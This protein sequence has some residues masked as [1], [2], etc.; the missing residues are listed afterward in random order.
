MS[1]SVTAV[2]GVQ[3]VEVSSR[4][5]H[6]DVA[7]VQ[8]SIY[9]PVGEEGIRCVLRAERM[10]FSSPLVLAVPGWP[11]GPNPNRV[12]GIQQGVPTVIDRVTMPTYYRV[13]R[14]LF[15]VE[16]ERNGLAITSEIKCIRRGEV[17]TYIEYAII[18]DSGLIPYELDVVTEGVQIQLMMHSHYEGGELTV[19]TS[20]IGIFN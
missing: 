10:D 19:R 17:V 6:I 4:E 13:A 16:D 11:F 18:G 15:L 3:S 20:K 7:M 5:E 2:E 12:S 14:W 8:E 9:P 1:D